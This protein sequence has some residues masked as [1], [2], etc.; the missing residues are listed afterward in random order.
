MCY[1]HTSGDSGSALAI[2]DIGSALA[3]GDSGSALASSDIGSA[4]ASS[5]TT[6][7]SLGRLLETISA[8]LGS[9][10]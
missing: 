10:R 8:I 3:S 4:L 9:R 6:T 7:V 2:G 5:K 1:P